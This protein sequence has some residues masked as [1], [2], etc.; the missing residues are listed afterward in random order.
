MM[1]CVY[2]KTGMHVLRTVI[3]DPVEFA[4]Q[5]AHYESMGFVV[6]TLG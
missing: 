2:S 6:D 4:Q 1:L 5:K 3:L